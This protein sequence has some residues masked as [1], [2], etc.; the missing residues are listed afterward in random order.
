MGYAIMRFS[1]L[2]RDEIQCTLDHNLRKY[3]VKTLTDKNKKNVQI[4]TQ[5]MIKNG[6]DRKTYEEVLHEKLTVKPKSNAVYGIEF[7][8][9][10]T[11]GSIKTKES[12]I[13]FTKSS[14][15][16]VESIFGE[17]S[18]YQ[19]VVHNDESTPHIHCTVQPVFEGKLNC[20]H[21]IDGRR[22]CQEM[23]D[24]FYEAV[25]HTGDLQRGINSNIT[26]AK[27]EKAKHFWGQLSEN[28]NLLDTYKE[29][30][31]TA[32]TWDTDTRENFFENYDKIKKK[33]EEKPIQ[34]EN[35]YHNI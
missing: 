18:V 11:K 7:I 8:F 1:K 17:D 21:F 14:V 13:D 27:N 34:T 28:Q 22:S 32:K 35:L 3:D 16:W 25:R 2:K 29:T 33:N 12:F 23:Q 26:H 15:K 20:K 19:I 6:Y 24:S 5:T 9:T 30:F 10:F 4:Y 31:G